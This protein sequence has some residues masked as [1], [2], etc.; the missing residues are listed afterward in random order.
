MWI[1]GFHGK[2]IQDKDG[3]K[4]LYTFYRYVFIVGLSDLFYNT[5]KLI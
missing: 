5:G 1:F 4:D 2:N 3:K